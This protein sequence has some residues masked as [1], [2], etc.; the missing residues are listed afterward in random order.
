MAWGM[1]CVMAWDIAYL[2]AAAANCRRFRNADQHIVPQLLE[3]CYLSPQADIPSEH[4]HMVQLA[5][6]LSDFKEP[7]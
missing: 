5:T 1:A 6:P 2:P 7:H 3:Y 4:G